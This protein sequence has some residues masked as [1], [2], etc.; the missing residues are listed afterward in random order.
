M[1]RTVWLCP[2]P[3]KFA[4][5]C[6]PIELLDRIKVEEK[7]DSTVE[8]TVP[9][10][11]KGYDC[12]NL[13]VTTYML[14]EDKTEIDCLFCIPAC[15]DIK[16]ESDIEEFRNLL[17][18]KHNEARATHPEECDPVVCR[19]LKLSVDLIA[20]AQ[21]F[22]EDMIAGD[23][24]ASQHEDRYGRGIAERFAAFSISY[25]Y[26]GENIAEI[27]TIDQELTIEELVD[28]F[29]EGWMNS[30]G[31]R[32]NIMK[33]EYNAV[34]IGLY[35]EIWPENGH[36]HRRWVAV[37]D[38]VGREDEPVEP[39][40]PAPVLP[41]TGE[42]VDKLQWWQDYE[43]VSYWD[44]EAQ[45]VRQKKV[46]KPYLYVKCKI[47]R[48]CG[49]KKLKFI[50]EISGC[51]AEWIPQKHIEEKQQEIPEDGNIKLIWHDVIGDEWILKWHL[52]NSTCFV[53][54]EWMAVLAEL[55][56]ED[57]QCNP[58]VIA[59]GWFE[60]QCWTSGTV[61]G[62]GLLD[63]NG[64]VIEGG[65]WQ[66]MEDEWIGDEKLHWLVRFKG[67]DFWVKSTDFARYEIGRRVFIHKDG[68]SK[69]SAGGSV[70]VEEPA[71]RFPVPTA[72]ILPAPDEVLSWSCVSYQLDRNRD[73]IV[74]QTFYGI[75]G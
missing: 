44:E 62:C 67:Q 55:D 48:I 30:P 23:Y 75:G 35:H 68:L 64:E 18:K 31:H 5:I 65:Y 3:W 12:S 58:F 10:C 63:E 43:L 39:V 69:A 56:I 45:E 8:V 25:I 1:E 34:G 49:L 46:P 16:S 9:L 32:A 41:C 28:I 4:G 59:Y 72:G 33:P 50:M 37:V 71:C 29:F 70:L 74:P 42:C 19:E 40:I 60:T 26:A 61:V 47:P 36:V 54:G 53:P 21:W 17:L 7:E 52:T 6:Y 38:F 2:T 20:V 73:V 57:E 24:Y 22:A 66:E 14:P 15:E 13:E 27:H 11:P 51:S